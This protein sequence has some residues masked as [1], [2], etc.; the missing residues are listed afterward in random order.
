MHAMGRFSALLA[1][2]LILAGCRTGG[3]PFGMTKY[4]EAASLYTLRDPDGGLVLEVT[5]F[6]GRLVRCWAPD[7]WGRLAD[8]ALG[9]NTVAEYERYGFSAG[10][11]VG[12]YANRIA[13]GRFSIDGREF[14]LAVNE[15]KPPRRSNIHGGPRGWSTKVWKVV[16]RSTSRIVF[17]LV[18]PDG[19]MGFPG[20][21]KARV[22]YS[23]PG[24]GR[25]VVRYEAVTDRP[26]V[27]NLTNHSYWNLAGEASGTVLGQRL[28]INADRYTQTDERR[29]PVKDAP[30]DGT[31]FDFRRPRAIGSMA[32]RM[33]A[34][35]EL[36][37]TGGWYD[38]NFVLNGAG[39]E[40][41]PAC[42]LSD[43]VSGRV[44]EI[45]TTEPCLQVYTAQDMT[46]GLPAKE[47]GRTLCPCAGVALETQ[48]YPDSPN[49]PEFPT[50]VLRPGETFRSET[51][52]RFGAR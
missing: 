42:E 31:V 7:R 8:V 49:H 40:M 1:S 13:D 16:E 47:K 50:T 26:T 20:T 17:E 38:H 43:P 2:V 23:V 4:G 41:K 11:L 10:A 9:W 37:A 3:L 14:R 25:W 36:R 6:G 21:V 33:A 32:D 12:R 28:A 24:G 18:S 30:V 29:I 34:L 15:A 39:G 48:H 44:L 22:T 19:D 46:T 35:P 52:Y 5:D 45:W 51:V 27:V